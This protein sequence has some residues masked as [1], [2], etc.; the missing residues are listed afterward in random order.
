M[1]ILVDEMPKTPNDCPYGEYQRNARGDS[2]VGCKK[3]SITCINTKMC[4]VFTE[5]TDDVISK[6]Y[7]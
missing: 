1:K 4:P 7:E 5:H 6:I 2:W 3:R